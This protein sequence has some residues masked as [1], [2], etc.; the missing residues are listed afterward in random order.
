MDK[1]HS[2]VR[3]TRLAGHVN[4]DISK[5][6]EVFWLVINVDVHTTCYIFTMSFHLLSQLDCLNL[7]TRLQK[8][9]PHATF[10]SSAHAL[11]PF[12]SQY[13]AFLMSKPLCTVNVSSVPLK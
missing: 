6:T 13:C 3:A 2:S 5:V 8:V 4:P 12:T 9:Q 10:S 7:T 1:Q 11:A